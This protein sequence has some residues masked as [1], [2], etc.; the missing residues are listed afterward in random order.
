MELHE[1]MYDSLAVYYKG[2]C[3]LARSAPPE[4]PVLSLRSTASFIS[5]AG[6]FRELV[7]CVATKIAE[8]KT[9]RSYK[10]VLDHLWHR[11]LRT[12]ID[13]G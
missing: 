7:P 4:A 1:R 10:P 5:E 12:H 6:D 13:M 2:Q 9:G 3:L 8:P 11:S